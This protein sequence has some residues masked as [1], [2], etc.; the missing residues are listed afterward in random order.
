MRLRVHQEYKFKSN[1]IAMSENSESKKLVHKIWTIINIIGI[2]V[3][4]LSVGIGIYLLIQAGTSSRG[5]EFSMN[6]PQ[7][8]T[9]RMVSGFAVMAQGSIAGIL[10]MAFSKMGELVNKIEINLSEKE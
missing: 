5:A 7:H 4:V 1:Y 2:A 10:L 8:S 3:I 6:I 9:M